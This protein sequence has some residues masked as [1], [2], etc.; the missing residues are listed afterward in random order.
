MSATFEFWED[1]GPAISSPPKGTTRTAARGEGN[2]KNVDDSVTAYTSSPV[3]AGN[4]SFDKWQFGR[5]TGAFNEI[6]N[7]LWAHTAGVLGAGLAVKG[8]VTSTYTTP[9]TT[10]NAALSVDM[11]PVIAIGSGQPVLFHTTGPEGATPTPTLT[12]AGYTQYL[13]TQL[14]TTVSAAA[15]DIASVALTLEY[16]EN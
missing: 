1:N 7:G 12:A 6:S 9:A 15:G 2:W 11:T 4:N 8:A 13:P 16:D 3:R 5:F 14:Q 10:A